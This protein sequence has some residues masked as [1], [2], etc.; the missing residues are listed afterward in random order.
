MA[1]SGHLDSLDVYATLLEP[2]TEPEAA[3]LW[4]ARQPLGGEVGRE[5]AHPLELA[6]HDEAVARVRLALGDEAFEGRGKS[7]AE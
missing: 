6:V 3:R 5:A 4:G 7:G 1:S 2:L